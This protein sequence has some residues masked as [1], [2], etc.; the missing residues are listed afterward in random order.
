[1]Q[2]RIKPSHLIWEVTVNW[3]KILLWGRWM[4]LRNLGAESPA[5]TVRLFPPH[6]FW[7]KCALTSCEHKKKPQVPDNFFSLPKAI[8]SSDW[9]E[10]FSNFFF[11]FAFKSD[12]YGHVPEFIIR[13]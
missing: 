6:M 12:M 2:E 5:G 4:S 11:F 3:G 8:Y 7:W 10:S 1:M 13:C 9:T